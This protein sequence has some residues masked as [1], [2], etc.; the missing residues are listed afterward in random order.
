MAEIDVRRMCRTFGLV[1]PS[2]QVK[3]RDSG[4]RA[5][6]T[7]CEWGLADG[8]TLVLEVDGGFHMAVEHWEDD[9][10]RQRALTSS[11]RLIVRCTARELRDE[12]ER[13]ARDLRLLGVPAA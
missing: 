8:R 1:L 2:R 12:P 9:L 4:G 11:D 5:R 13:V 3:R 10:A 6:F 7:D